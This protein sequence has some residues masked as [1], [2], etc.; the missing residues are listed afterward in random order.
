VDSEVAKTADIEIDLILS[1]NNFIRD[2][3]QVLS[4]VSIP[5]LDAA[6]KRTIETS[7]SIPEALA[8][9]TYYIHVYSPPDQTPEDQN[10]DNNHIFR[11]VHITNAIDLELNLKLNKS[12]FKPGEEIVGS[13]ILSNSET[14][15]V[16]ET[17]IIILLSEDNFPDAE[18][19]QIDQINVTQLIGRSQQE[20]SFNYTVPLESK[21]GTGNLISFVDA[22]GSIVETS[23][24]NNFSSASY[25]VLEF[26]LQLA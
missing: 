20:F 17:E 18:D 5:G 3:D 8:E 9:N 21:P 16:A 6:E 1:E 2:E 11:Q 24:Q 12:E 4:I 19:E 14:K 23:E 25:K 7:I 15:D 22:I 26:Q 13:I 10:T